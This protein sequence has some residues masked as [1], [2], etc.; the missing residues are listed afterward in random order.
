[1]YRALMK[2]VLLSGLA[3]LS[4]ESLTA[5]SA[6][7]TLS[8]FVHDTQE[9]S[10]PNAHIV[11]EQISTHI[12]HETDSSAVGAYNIVDL[13]IGDYRVTATAPNFKIAVIPTLTL[14]RPDDP[15]PRALR[16]PDPAS[17][18]RRHRRAHRDRRARRLRAAA[19][20]AQ[21][22]RRHPVGRPAV[23]EAAT[24]MGMTPAPAAAAGRAAAGAARRSS[25][26]CASRSSSA[27][28]TATIAAAIGAGGLGVLIFRGLATVDTG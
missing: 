15:E 9:G 3:V 28:G 8:G 4:S 14:H 7:A 24:A 27:I 10:V 16:L 18:H 5:Q 6:N 25:P 17:V 2:A 1:M 23:V 26:A 12:K 21:H 19:D 20:P 13:P 22:R 11:A